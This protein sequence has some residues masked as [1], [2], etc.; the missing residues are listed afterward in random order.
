MTV[1]V[2]QRFVPGAR[3]IDG[4]DLNTMVDQINKALANLSTGTLTATGAVV[5]SNASVKMTALPTADPHVVGQ[6]WSS[7]GTLTVSAG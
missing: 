6:I 4:S 5:L 3:L 1:A 7:T 2:K